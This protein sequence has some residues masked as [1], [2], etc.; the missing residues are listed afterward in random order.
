M[1]EAQIPQNH[2]LRLFFMILTEKNFNEKLNWPDSN[3]INYISNLLID[4]IHIDKL[5]AIRN[6]QGKPVVAVSEMLMEGDLMLR[7]QTIERERETHRRIGDY[8]LF[9]TG[10]FPEYLKRLK[11]ESKIENPDFMIDYIKVGKK[12]YRRVSEFNYGRFQ[13]WTALYRKLSDNFEV[14]IAGLGLIKNDLDRF[15]DWRV[16]RRILS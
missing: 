14:C 15:K 10:V 5:Y 11:F 16:K 7:A 8:T 13:K 6:A 9:M 1:S 4:F 12:S 3:V 2:P